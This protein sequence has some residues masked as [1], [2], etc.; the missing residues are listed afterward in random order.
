MTRFRPTLGQVFVLANAGL[1]M[2]LA[3]L[4][5]LLYRSSKASIVDTSLVLLAATR[6]HSAEKVGEYLRQAERAVADV[7][8]DVR[9]GIIA[10]ENAASVEPQLL[11]DLLNDGNLAEVT[12]THAA[13]L[14]WAGDGT[15]QLSP[16][17]RWQIS[18]FR[19]T[20]DAS[21]TILTRYTRARTPHRFGSEARPPRPRSDAVAD[22]APA[23]DA[24]DPTEHPTFATLVR[25]DLYG[26][27][28]WSDLSYS[29]IDASLPEAQ[30][31]VVVTV[32]KAI[33]DEQGRFVGVVRVGLRAD[34]LGAIVRQ[35]QEE[36]AK[37]TPLRL[38][39]CDSD[40]RLITPANADDRLAEGRDSSLRYAATGATRELQ[41]ALTH[42]ALRA[43]TGDTGTAGRLTES[44]R[45]LL[46]GFRPVHESQDWRVGV[47]VAEDEIPAI[48]T[49]TQNRDR[50]LMQCIGLMAL[51]LAGGI[52]VLRVVQ[53]GLGTIVSSTGRMREF[54]FSPSDRRSALGDVRAAI[55][56]LELAKTAL[57]S[58]AK[59][60]PVDL[61]RLLYRTGREPVLGG[62]LAVVTMMFTDIESFTTLSER[63]SPDE[64]ARVLGSYLQVMTTTIQQHQGTID[65]YIGDAVMAAWNTPSPCTDHVQ[66]ACA[67]ALDC[68]AATARL[69]ASTEWRDTPPL[70]TRFGL[71]VDEV[72]V[73]HFGAPDRMS[74]TCLGD[75]VNLAS[76]LEGLNK[77]YG[78]TIIASEAVREQAGDGFVFR[79]VDVVAVKGKTKGVRVY[80]L[81]GTG[82]ISGGRL[83]AARRY[84]QAFEAYRRRDFR[85]A[86]ALVGAQSAD[87]PSVVLADR[88]RRFIEHPPPADW[89]GTYVASSK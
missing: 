26:R 50:L 27:T 41:A 63:L 80:E 82:G 9:S 89:D 19:Q 14:G 38:F 52:I 28:V 56:S 61:V 24:S 83:E 22:S 79:L 3:G 23:I 37:Q 16:E 74:F 85:G 6:D 70:V 46:V 86:L 11:S 10:P 8:N 35:V 55:E 69:F 30:R 40:G 20:P 72:M 66:K 84:E 32:M 21:S 7:E 43:A 81:L 65:K 59:Y 76:R 4:F 77:Q 75:G 31:R 71:H 17:G 36:T 67:A 1:A 54:D 49:L 53:R 42:P 62:E 60:V 39:L 88:C 25:K 13:R 51:L 47:L 58:M 78:T 45:A 68:T 15:M 44:G 57:R 18:V 29:E 2:L 12:F 33:E 87:G 73:G 5:S 64:L 34:R 48:R